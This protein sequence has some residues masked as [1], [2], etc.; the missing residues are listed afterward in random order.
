MF[1]C[2][3]LV[4]RGRPAHALLATSLVASS[5]KLHL[6]TEAQYGKSVKKKKKS[7]AFG[8]TT[9]ASKLSEDLLRNECVLYCKRDGFLTSS[10]QLIDS[11][12]LPIETP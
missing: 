12:L 6:E 3:S 9:P 5:N 4:L 7:I 1:S 2:C 10:G 8:V 11:H